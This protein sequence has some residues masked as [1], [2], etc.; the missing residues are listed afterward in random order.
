MIQ[1]WMDYKGNVEEGHLIHS[2]MGF[3]E[4]HLPEEVIVN[5]H[6]LTS[7]YTKNGSKEKSSANLAT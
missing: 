7:W 6:E 1:I 4:F 2:Q 5:K 3:V